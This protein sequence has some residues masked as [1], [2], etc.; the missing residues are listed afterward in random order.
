VNW[1]WPPDD[2]GGKHPAR[3]RATDADDQLFNE[4]SAPEH[5][6]HTLDR[7]P[8]GKTAMS[9]LWR[10]A[11]RR[12]ALAALL[13]PFSASPSAAAADLRKDCQ[14][15]QIAACTQILQSNPSDI[16]A[17]GNRGIGFRVIGEYDRAVA[18]LNAAVGLDPRIAGLYRATPLWD[19][20][21]CARRSPASAAARAARGPG[22]NSE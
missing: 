3:R 12:K 11:V 8:P 13:I 18:D 2:K 15:G 20:L 16:S 17:L 5:A 10:L 9:N 6:G 4:G 1:S 21:N 19:G 22:G 7:R 14:S